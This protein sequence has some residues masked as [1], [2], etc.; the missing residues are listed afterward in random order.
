[1]RFGD[2]DY[3]AAE[4]KK[5]AKLLN[6]RLKNASEH[7]TRALPSCKNMLQEE[8]KRNLR[9]IRDNRRYGHDYW[10]IRKSVL[11]LRKREAKAHLRM[12]R[13]AHLARMAKY[14]TAS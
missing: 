14:T 10:D 5:E 4:V 2:E 1:M 8:K 12:D 13:L 9:C 11:K 6:K 3:T 7:A